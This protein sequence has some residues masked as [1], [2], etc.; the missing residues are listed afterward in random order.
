MSRP[1]NNPDFV[2]KLCKLC[3]CS[4][5]VSFYKR[6]KSTY[7]SKKCANSDEDVL[8]KMRTSQRNTYDEKYN[9]VHPMQT[10]A[11]KQN[12]K[13]SLLK[14]YGV[15][16]Y[17]KLDEYKNKVK[18]TKLKNHGDEN[19]INVEK[20]KQTVLSKYGVDNVMK[21]QNIKEK[22]KKTCISKYGVD[23]YSK[24]ISSINNHHNLTYSKILLFSNVV[25]LFSREEFLGV[26]KNI[27]YKF[28]CNRCDSIISLDLK[29]GNIPL[30]VNCDKLNT[31]LA[32]K[33]IYDF[34]KK[35]VNENVILNDRNLIYPKEID[36]YIPSLKIG[37]EYNSFYYHTEITGNKNKL[38]HL[39]KLQSSLFKGINLIQIFEN[40]WNDKK[41]IVQS[42]LRNKLNS[43]DKKIYARKCVVKEIDALESNQFLNQNHI[44]GKDHAGIRL[45]LYYND[46]LISLMTFV[47]SRY[48]KKIQ[49]EMSRFCN[50]LNH[51]VVGGASKLFKHFIKNYNPKSIVSYS[52]RRFFNGDVY[53]K[54]N[55]TFT[56]NTSP[57]Y[58][59]IKNKICYNRMTFQKHKLKKLLVDYNN[60][61]TEWEN[62]MQNG[63]D[64]IWDC[65]H[66]KWIWNSNFT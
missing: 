18:S 7:C 31:S 56:T 40:D 3:G 9:G 22:C 32:Q 65:G 66:S 45:G 2:D 17:S 5:K 19:Y 41:E 43:F 37:I 23:H 34:I 16:S 39:R 4:Y 52:D 47:K 57:C 24:S 46:E 13:D 62:M 51:L 48:D 1:K 59:Y 49:Y 28:K 25:P 26:T 55:F 11:T 15:E 50:K 21:L 53:Q 64:R 54:L 38:Y 61:L 44:Q 14:K 8:N 30:C 63:Y 12:L 6:K 42:I 35:Y 58:F 10:E 20:I 29:D 27:Q 36:I 33:E 60:D